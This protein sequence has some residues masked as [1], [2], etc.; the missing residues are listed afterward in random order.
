MK[1]EDIDPLDL[2]RILFGEVPFVFYI[3]LIFRTVFIYAMLMIAMRLMGKKVASE[4]GRNEMIAMVSMAA[5]IGVPL[6]SPDRGLLPALIIAG[7]VVA[8]QQLIAAK[9]TTSEK[10]ETITQDKISTL[11]SDSC[12]ELEEM[13]RTRL[14][15]ERVFGQL[16]N[17]GYCQLGEVRRMYLEANGTF[18]F[19][20][21]EHAVPGLCI[22]PDWD[23]DYINKL[24]NDTGKQVCKHCGKLFAQAGTENRQ[25]DNCGK[26]EWG[27]AVI[28]IKA[29]TQ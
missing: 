16:R 27:R 8:L 1:K 15:R 22:L 24:C 7:I 26:N 11:V 14:T 25:C 12:L 4:L 2:A 6:Q 19:I 17:Q 3:E 29:K 18:T 21:H 20:K 5:A 23:E 10:F 13:S 28:N 9:T